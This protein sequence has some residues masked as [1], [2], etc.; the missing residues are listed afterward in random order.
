MTGNVPVPVPAGPQSANPLH[1]PASG[2]CAD[3]ANGATAPGT[4]VQLWDCNA[5]EG[6]DWAY[7]PVARTLVGKGGLCLDAAG[8]GSADGTRLIGWTCSGDDNQRWTLTPEGTLTGVGGTC[9]TAADGGTAG[10]TALQLGTC[11]P[12]SPSQTWAVALV[13]PASARCLTAAAGSGAPVTLEDCDRGARQR[14]TPS[15]TSAPVTAGNGMCLDTAGGGSAHGTQ[16]VVAPCGGGAG[17]DWT[18]TTGGALTGVGGS[19]LD[20]T[21]GATAAGSRLRLWPCDGG[22]AQRW[23][24]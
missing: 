22:S 20:V 2:R 16:V 18:L 14:W 1:H 10:G 4:P 12:G 5:S 9:V 7:D 6:Q 19:C 23:V 15:G 17:Q 3:L 24:L 21:D 11:V 13:N 8:G